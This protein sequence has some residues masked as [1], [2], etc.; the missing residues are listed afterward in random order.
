MTDRMTVCKLWE[1]ENRTG[2]GDIVRLT[3]NE[4]TGG[5]GLT[6]TDKGVPKVIVLT[7]ED[8]SRL[9]LAAD[10][11]LTGKALQQVVDFEISERGAG[12]EEYE[13]SEKDAMWERGEE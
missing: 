11:Y 7:R 3:V 9:I 1:A 4:E 13:R 12:R 8:V 5:F 6:V 10:A 2:D